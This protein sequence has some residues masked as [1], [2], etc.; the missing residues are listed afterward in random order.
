MK[1]FVLILS[2][3]LLLPCLAPA[4]QV[5]EI[6]PKRVYD[7]IKE[8]SG[9]WLIDVRP[10]AVFARGHIE[11]ALNI[12]TLELASKQLPQN[13]ILVL[14]D[15][16]LGQLEAHQAA[17][18]IARLGA[19]KIFVLAG[20]VRGWQLTK[21]PFVSSGNDF[22]LAR[23]FPGELE[24]ARKQGVELALYD[25]RTEFE[26]E[27]SPLDGTMVL[28]AETFSE[29]LELLRKKLSIPNPGALTALVESPPTVVVL[30]ATIRASNLYQ[31][32]LWDLPGNVRVLEGAYVAGGQGQS[33]KMTS[34]GCAT[35]P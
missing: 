26:R 7:L 22:E 27:Q 14:A 28:S 35:C 18:E 31:Q 19:K 4:Q 2:I 16:S 30:P 34:G 15:N 33:R 32:S 29:K 21:L 13:K 5:K 12:P 6:S 24:A 20:G 23:V 1:K 25:L 11:G 10:P 17:G 9:L 3:M 8:G